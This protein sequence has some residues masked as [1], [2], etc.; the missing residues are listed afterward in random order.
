MATTDPVG[1][2]TLEGNPQR[3]QFSFGDVVFSS[4]FDSGNLLNVVRVD[5][6]HVGSVS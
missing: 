1:K 6:L 2:A 3:N 5:D 4:Q